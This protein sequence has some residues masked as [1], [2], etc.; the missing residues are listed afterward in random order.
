MRGAS[1]HG[2]ARLRGYVG[3]GTRPAKK[4]GCSIITKFNCH[5]SGNPEKLCAFTVPARPHRPEESEMRY[6]I[7]DWR[8]G[9]DVVSSYAD[10][11]N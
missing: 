8:E 2:E 5:Y 4:D 11:E 9:D 10:H 1:R 7:V 6:P 3:R